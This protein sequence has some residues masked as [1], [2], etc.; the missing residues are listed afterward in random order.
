M[1]RRRIRGEG[2]IY[3]RHFKTCPPKDKEGNRAKHSCKGLY[4]GTIDLGWYNGKRV[5]KSVTGT[6]EKAVREKF[7]DLKK[8]VEKGGGL[9][10][11]VTVAEW[12]NHW[13]KYVVSERNRGTTLEGYTSRVNTWL[14]PYLGKHR[15]DR[16]SE[17]HIR[18][19][20]AEMKEQGRSEATR[21]RT[22]A[23]LRRALVV[24]MREGR[25]QRN[26]AAMMDAPSTA[27]KH[28]RP[29][30]S[31]QVR[32]ILSQLDGN[33]LA[34]RWLAALLL[35][36]RQGECLALKWEDV[37]F[38]NEEIKIRRSQAR[39][40]DQGLVETLPKSANSVRTI[41]MGA[42]M[43]FALENTERRGEYVFYG[44]PQDAKKDWKNWKELLISTGV[45]PADMAFGDMPELAVGRT[46]TAT[47]MR[48]GG[49]EATVIRDFLGHSQVSITQE[50]YMRTDKPSMKRALE[51]SVIDPK[52]LTSKAL[53][54]K[55]PK[56]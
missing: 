56:T 8:T 18:A 34:A 29:L 1:A 54:Q 7:L 46:T 15:L 45:C 55:K 48:D 5:R 17:D 26:P 42:L 4:V 23:V 50:S 35:G 13:L 53:P 39:L 33:P 43:R 51:A 9:T 19:M 47:A 12:L 52:K 24:A 22:Y 31:G 41:P 32:Q 16:L 44:A 40:K 27:V 49:A 6:T 14:I 21:R 20:L 3:Q 37:D 2:S 11:N 30:D 25:I 36:M 10:K 28:R 38:L